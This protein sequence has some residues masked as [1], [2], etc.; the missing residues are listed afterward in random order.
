MDPQ[1]EQVSKGLQNP[2]M[3]AK[4]RRIPRTLPADSTDS[5][6]SRI[7][8]PRALDK[9]EKTFS[10]KEVKWEEGKEGNTTSRTLR[11][12]NYLKTSDCLQVVVSAVIGDRYVLH[13]N[14]L[15][16]SCCCCCF[17]S[18]RLFMA[19]VRAESAECGGCK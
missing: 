8:A 14:M 19:D 3:K 6:T 11:S 13:V 2:D 1:K 10:R 9:T 4:L 16:V 12:R 17:C 7:A 18:L 5:E 15:D